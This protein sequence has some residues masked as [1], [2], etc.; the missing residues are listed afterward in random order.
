MPVKAFL[1]T[2]I[3]IYAFSEGDPRKSDCSWILLM[4]KEA[5]LA[6]SR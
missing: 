1:D 2:N 3:L 5:L 6:S 4:S